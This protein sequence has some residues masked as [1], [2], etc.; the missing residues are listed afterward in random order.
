MCRTVPKFACFSFVAS[1]GFEFTYKVGPSSDGFWGRNFLFSGYAQP[2]CIDAP[3]PTPSPSPSPSPSPPISDLC[4]HP[5][6]TIED[7]VEAILEAVRTL[8]IKCIIYYAV[9]GATSE[10]GFTACILRAVQK[11]LEAGP[12]VGIP[13][14]INDLRLCI[15]DRPILDPI[16]PPGAP[17]GDCPYGETEPIVPTGIESLLDAVYAGDLDAIVSCS[18]GMPTCVLALIGDFLGDSIGISDLVSGIL[19]CVLPN[20]R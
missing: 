18:V 5:I 8:D 17:V 4:P 6:G 19:S 10:E 11:Y 9:N 15:V 2:Y 16:L 1:E 7:T 20:G 12:V 13:G 3:I 14:F